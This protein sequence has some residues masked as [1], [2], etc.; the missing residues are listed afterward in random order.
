MNAPSVNAAH[1]HPRKPH[2]PPEPTPLHS[3]APSAPAAIRGSRAGI[4]LL[5]LAPAAEPSHPLEVVA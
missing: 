2:S 3:P 1:S 4:T 5:P